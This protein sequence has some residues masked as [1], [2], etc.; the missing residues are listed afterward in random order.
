MHS[1]LVRTQNVFGY[2]TTV[3]FV[4]ALFVAVSVLLSPQ[5]PTANI[6]LRNVQVLV[7]LLLNGLLLFVNRVLGSRGDHTTTRVRKRSTL[8]SNLISTLVRLSL[9]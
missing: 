8:I 7:A 4:T 2:F 6:Q 3:A 1:S 9:S 5:T